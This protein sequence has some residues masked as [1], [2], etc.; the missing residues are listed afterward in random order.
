MTVP[1]GPYGQPYGPP[2]GGYPIPHGAG[3]LVVHSSYN[4]MAFI[5]AATGPKVEING[6]PQPVNWGQ[7]PF[8]LPPGDYHLKVSTRYM[9]EYGPAYLP[10]R[11]TPGQ[12]TT[13]FYRPPATIGMKGA[14]GFTPQN[15]RGMSALMVIQFVVIALVV[16]YFIVRFS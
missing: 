6:R 1:P 11:I 5:L 15:T 14:L 16:T 3:R 9:G 4:K 13:V 12:V 7:A 8:D 10:V 2:P